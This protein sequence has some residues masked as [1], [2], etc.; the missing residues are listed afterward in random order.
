MTPKKLAER[1]EERSLS[2]IERL[3]KTVISV[4]NKAYG[5]VVV[6][7]RNLSLD[8]DGYIIQNAENRAIIREANKA[9]ARALERGGYIDGLNR[10]T[11]V[12][13]E[14]DEVNG[15]YFGGFDGFSP[16]RQF[17]KALQRQAIADIEASLLNEGLTAQIKQPLSQMLNQNVNTGGSFT[18]MLDQVRNFIKGDGADGRLLRHVKTITRDVLFNY[19]RTFQSAVASDLGLEF[20][21][22][23]GGII[24]TSRSW[25]RGKAG[26]FYHHREIEQWAGEQWAGKRPDTTESSIFLYAGGY[27]CLHQILP[28]SEVIVP[29]EVIQ[30]AVS[31]GYYKKKA[32]A[33]AGA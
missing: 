4:Q 15:A 17:I 5:D 9:F 1:I 25:C 23:T 11:V 24:K 31:L 28:V 33:P 16:N 7:L 10:F 8:S 18:G 19:S 6:T 14:L 27:G 21:L 22:Y 20:Y 13:S 12:F 29:M 2:A 26:N 3:N 30:R 32:P